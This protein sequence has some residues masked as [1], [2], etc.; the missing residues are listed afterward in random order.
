MWFYW[1]LS[2][3][4]LI[5]LTWTRSGVNTDTML[6]FHDSRRSVLPL[7]SR[8]AC[9]PVA[10]ERDPDRKSAVF[11]CVGR[12]YSWTGCFIRWLLHNDRST[13]ERFLYRK[14]AA[15][16]FSHAAHPRPERNRTRSSHSEIF[17]LAPALNNNY[18]IVATI[19]MERCRDFR[20]ENLNTC[21]EV[22]VD[23]VL[24]MEVLRNLCAG[25]FLM[26]IR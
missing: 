10:G 18:G 4:R 11:A 22:A 13:V 21:D 26:L 3:A 7:H 23:R 12:A 8:G 2:C 1:F 14:Y 20:V 25:I 6:R 24:P 16:P 9:L 15:L 19:V 5:L 17:T